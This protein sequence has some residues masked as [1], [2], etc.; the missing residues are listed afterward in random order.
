MTLLMRAF[1][2]GLCGQ[3]SASFTCE[4]LFLLSPIL[5]CGIA[6]AMERKTCL[7][8]A[9]SV[10]INLAAYSDCVF[11]KVKHSLKL[12]LRWNFSSRVLFTSGEFGLVGC[13]LFTN[14]LGVANWTVNLMLIVLFEFLNET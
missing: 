3:I 7:G 10:V 12:K 9:S 14:R 1:E 6:N 2:F 13:S 5:S 11:K 4:M 8:M